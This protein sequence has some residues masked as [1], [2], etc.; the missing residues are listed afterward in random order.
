MKKKAFYSKIAVFSELKKYSTFLEDPEFRL[1]RHYL[2]IATFYMHSRAIALF[3]QIWKLFVKNQVFFKKPLFRSKKDV[4]KR[5][6]N[7][8]RILEHIGCNLVFK[9]LTKMEIVQFARIIQLAS[10]LENNTSDERKNFLPYHK[11]EWKIIKDSM[12]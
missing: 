12:Q 7:L 3:F 4:L 1:E 9:K 10:K 2:E 6:Y 8:R 5:H 11:S